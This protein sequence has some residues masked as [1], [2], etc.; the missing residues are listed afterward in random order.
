VASLYPLFQDEYTTVAA[1]NCAKV[2]FMWDFLLRTF[3]ILVAKV[4]PIR[5]KSND[6]FD[7]IMARA[8]LAKAQILDETGKLNA[9]NA[10]VGNAKYDKGIEFGEEIKE[11]AKR[12]DDDKF[13][14]Y[15]KEAVAEKM[16]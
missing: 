8:S 5:P 9:M 12:L 3:Q 13:P 14:D 16:S 6:Y 11:L 15:I 10:S 1:T 2:Y 4:D 7:E